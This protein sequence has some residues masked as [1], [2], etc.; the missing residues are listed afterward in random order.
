MA[1]RQPHTRDPDVRFTFT[2]WQFVRNMVRLEESAR[3]RGQRPRDQLYQRWQLSW[4]E[5]DEELTRIGQSDL[6]GF[7]DLMMDHDVV[8]SCQST[9]QLTQVVRVIEEVVQQLSKSIASKDGDTEQL[10]HLRFERGELEKLKKRVAA[11]RSARK[12]S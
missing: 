7:A 4:L 1:T 8:V 12:P 3:L 10:R 6:G 11:R 5:I 9:S 2:V